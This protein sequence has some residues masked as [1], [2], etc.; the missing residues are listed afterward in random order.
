VRI[1]VRSREGRNGKEPHSLCL[2]RRE[3]F[4]TAILERCELTGECRFRVRVA[5]GR[6]FLI[7]HRPAADVWELAAV[8]GPLPPRRR[9]LI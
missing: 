3:L 4:V 5:D 6:R 1:S 7:H 2:G 8:Y 9:N